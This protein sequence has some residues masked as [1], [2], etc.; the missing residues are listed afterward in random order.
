MTSTLTA[1]KIAIAERALPVIED[2]ALGPIHYSVPKHNS[3]W[4]EQGID[5]HAD[6]LE[7]NT[8]PDQRKVDLSTERTR[9]RV[10][11]YYSFMVTGRW[12]VGADSG[13]TLGRVGES[14]S[15]R[16]LNDQHR[17]H[18]AKRAWEEKGIYVPFELHYYTFNS[19]SEL[20]EFFASIDDTF[21]RTMGQRLAILGSADSIGL[22][23]HWARAAAATIRTI[24]AEFRGTS[25]AQNLGALDIDAAMRSIGTAAYAYYRT[26]AEDKKMGEIYRRSAVFGVGLVS[27]VYNPEIATEFWTEVANPST[28]LHGSPVVTLREFLL[29]TKVIGGSGDTGVFGYAKR[30]SRAY[31]A[32]C[33]GRESLTIL[34][35]TQGAD[36]PVEISGTP[37]NGKD[38]NVGKAMLTK[39]I[40]EGSK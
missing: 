32:Y 1:A 24:S 8:H 9:S 2:C 11:R 39:W 29:T 3:R 28:S 35:G 40:Q 15:Y 14:G 23:G 7:K 16:L 20:S 6:L 13:I 21:N 37:F 25:H 33:E 5:T 30:V 12:R 17:L 27:M 38:W 26:S 31:N 36:K 19:E 22:P 4:M 34:R 10:N 18:S